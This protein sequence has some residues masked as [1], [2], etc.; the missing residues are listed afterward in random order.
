MDRK[1]QLRLARTVLA[2][3]SWLF[4][5][6]MLAALILSAPEVLAALTGRGPQVQL[7]DYGFVS[8][9]LVGALMLSI[10][11]AALWHNAVD[12]RNRNAPKSVTQTLL[13]LGTFVAGLFYYFAFLVWESRPR[14]SQSTS[15]A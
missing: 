6:L 2:V 12:S 7:L 15:G 3:S 8:T 10:W 9:L 5:G 1:E 4:L 11:I 14:T 13:F